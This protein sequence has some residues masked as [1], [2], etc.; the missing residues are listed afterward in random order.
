MRTTT[1]DQIEDKTVYRYKSSIGIKQ[2]QPSVTNIKI[3][4]DMALNSYV[5]EKLVR[6]GMLGEKWE[7]CTEE[8][9]QIK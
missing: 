4:K 6:K 8:L 1:T 5:V 7:D 2:W 9:K 3:A